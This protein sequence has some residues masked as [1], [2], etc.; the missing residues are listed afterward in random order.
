M[1]IWLAIISFSF[2]MGAAVRGGDM[3]TLA[4]IAFTIAFVVVANEILGTD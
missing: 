4:A 2:G 3:P 1:K